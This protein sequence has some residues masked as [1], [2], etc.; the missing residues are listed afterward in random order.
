VDGTG[1]VRPAHPEDAR[2][3]AEVHVAGWR[4]GYRGLFPQPYLDALDVDAHEQRWAR[5]LAGGLAVLVH[6]EQP[7]GRVDGFATFG[8]ARDD[9]VPASAGEVYG[10]YVHPGAWGRGTGGALLAAAV[11]RLRRERRAEQPLDRQADDRGDDRTD[12]RVALW[13]LEGNRRARRFYAHQGWVED[14]ARRQG[15][16]SAVGTVPGIVFT[17]VRYR[18]AADGASAP[19]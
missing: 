13:A 10:L 12:D 2:A 18:L 3:I 8:P 1:A 7:G 9:D 19:S 4:T 6:D 14:G 17:E 11:E 15:E 16:R 5:N